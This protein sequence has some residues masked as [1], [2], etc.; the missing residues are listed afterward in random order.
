MLISHNKLTP[1]TNNKKLAVAIVAVLLPIL[2]L[3]ISLSL[4]QIPFKEIPLWFKII[5]PAIILIGLFSLLCVFKYYKNNSDAETNPAISK[6]VF[7]IA[8]ILFSI[9]VLTT[10]YILCDLIFFFVLLAILLI[11]GIYI[12]L[13]K[14]PSQKKS[15]MQSS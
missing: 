3:S 10:T 6:N 13:V 9:V 8:Y 7:L 4:T 2:F 5:N 1:M 11:F 15:D 12:A 14:T